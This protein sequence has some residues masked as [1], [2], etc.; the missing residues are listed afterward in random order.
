MTVDCIDGRL[1]GGRVFFRFGRHL[2]GYGDTVGRDGRAAG[3]RIG[4]PARTARSAR[5]CLRHRLAGGLPAT[6]P[7]F[8][9]DGAEHGRDGRAAGAIFRAFAR[10]PRRAHPGLDR[11]ARTALADASRRH[12]FRLLP[13]RPR[14]RHRYYGRRG[15]AAFL[16]RPRGLR[17][18][19]TAPRLLP[20]R[21]GTG[22]CAARDVRGLRG[23]GG[24][25]MRGQGRRD[26]V[27][28]A[29]TPDRPRQDYSRADLVLE[30]LAAFSPEML[31]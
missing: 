13:R 24:G 7:A 31:G 8:P 26:A 5:D 17:A 25:A 27:C 9:R 4:P 22:R 1:D 2:A 11:A 23:L 14:G 3:V 30:D 28:G 21:G 18:G 6:P 20:V 19:Q 29:G 15:P 16:S 10:D 12:R